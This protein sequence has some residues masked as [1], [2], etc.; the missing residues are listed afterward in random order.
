MVEKRFEIPV[1]KWAKGR[2]AKELGLWF[3]ADI[4]HGL[5]ASKVMF[6]KVLGWGEER[7]EGLLEGVRKDLVGSAVHAFMPL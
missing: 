3:A 2:K 5:D 4:G 6:L 7:V 1:G